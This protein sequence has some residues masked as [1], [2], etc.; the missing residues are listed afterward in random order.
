MHDTVIIYYI[1]RIIKVEKEHIYSVLFIYIQTHTVNLGKRKND[2]TITNG[3]SILCIL[4]TS[5]YVSLSLSLSLSFYPL[6]IIEIF[7]LLYR[8]LLHCVQAWLKQQSSKGIGEIVVRLT[9]FFFFFFF[10]EKP[11]I[12]I[13]FCYI[14]YSLT[15]DKT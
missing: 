2:H 12:F 8:I 9:F 11:T 7:L 15:F 4:E 6:L 5:S 14:E 1:N 10:C 3:R 13:N